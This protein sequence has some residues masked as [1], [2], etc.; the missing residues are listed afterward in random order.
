M[1]TISPIE[2]ENAQLPR[3]WKGFKEGAVRAILA[4]AARTLE[5]L[6]RENRELSIECESLRRQ[7]ARFETQEHTMTEALVLAQRASADLRSSA[8]REAE[9]TVKEAEQK[10]AAIIRDAQAQAQRTLFQNEAVKEEM[11]QF[12]HQ[13][14]ELLTGYLEQIERRGRSPHLKVEVGGADAGVG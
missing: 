12:H 3:G 13:F 14:K 6:I 5:S 11:A 4:Q 2:L 8:E 1:E 10:A 9:S 7:V